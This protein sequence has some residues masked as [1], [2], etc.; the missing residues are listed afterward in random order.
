MGLR[1]YFVASVLLV[2]P[3]TQ[4]LADSWAPPSERVI[5]SNDESKLVRFVPKTN[6]TVLIVSAIQTDSTNQLWTTRTAN[7]PHE[8]HVSNNGSNVVTCN[9]WAGIGYGD[10]VV[11]IYSARG[12]LA[13]YPLEAFAPAPRSTKNQMGVFSDRDRYGSLFMH[14]T[15]SRWWDNDS[16]KLFFPHDN[17]S[18]F[19]IWLPWLERWVAFDLTSGKNRSLK[20]AELEKLTEQTASSARRDLASLDEGDESVRGHGQIRALRFLASRKN[21]EDRKFVVNAMRSKSFR[22]GIGAVNSTPTLFGGSDL[23]AAADVI[24]AK[25]DGND[26]KLRDDAEHNLVA[27]NNQFDILVNL[28]A[29]EGTVRF[30]KPVGKAGTLHIYLE[31]VDS[32]TEGDTVAEHSFFK[33]FEF[34][35]YFQP[36]E[37]LPFRLKNISPGRYRF[38]VIHDIAKPFAQKNAPPYQASAGD[39]FSLES[40]II[41]VKAGE[42]T[43]VTQIHCTTEAK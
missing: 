41:A 15:S 43:R 20:A 25:W 39:Y 14:T 33:T 19:C 38:K 13:H 29:I 22:T 32:R 40:P 37:S 8:I 23:R 2:F 31:P 42:T 27:G 34:P 36:G 6:K 24:L 17:E 18:L 7:I 3:H 10:Y 5:K 1:L 30:A 26:K 4:I 35:S 12:E 28:G 16:Y 11:A 9:S 21:P